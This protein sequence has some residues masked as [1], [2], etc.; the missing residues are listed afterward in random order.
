LQHNVFTWPAN[1]SPL[2]LDDAA[3]RTLA[4][5]SEQGRGIDD[6]Y[7]ATLTMRLQVAR[8]Q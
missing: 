4:W 3:A 6:D 5:A 7:S 8:R 2:M 1:T